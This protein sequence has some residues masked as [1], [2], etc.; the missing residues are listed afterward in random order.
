MKTRLGATL[1]S[2][3]DDG[4]GLSAG[5]ELLA[6]PWSFLILQAALQDIVTFEAL[7]RRLGMARNV[8]AARLRLLV[9]N[10]VMRRVPDPEREDR[11][12]YVLTDAGRDFEA[13]LALA[14]AWSD[15]HFGPPSQA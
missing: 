3:R 13:V 4:L 7:I 14:Q 5:H 11:F 2:V 8:L 10:G 6:D 9:D 15:R 12:R 1:R